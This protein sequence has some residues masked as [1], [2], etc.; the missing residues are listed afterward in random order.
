MA[1]VS[2]LLFRYRKCATKQSSQAASSVDQ[3]ATL[4]S[5][6]PYFGYSE[7]KGKCE[8]YTEDDC[9]TTNAVRGLSPSPTSTIPSRPVTQRHKTKTLS[10]FVVALLQAA[11]DWTVYKFG[12]CTITTP[13]AGQVCS[14]CTLLASCRSS[15][16]CNWSMNTTIF[17]HMSDVGKLQEQL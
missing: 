11:S 2:R 15:Y 12:E 17:A 14:A 5:G 13:Y 10:G 1:L 8:I 4:A 9:L 7:D 16:L 6:Y 3:C